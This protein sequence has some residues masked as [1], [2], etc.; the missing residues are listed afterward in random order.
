M[1][2]RNNIA[3]SETGFV[4]DP[5]TGDSFTLNETGKQILTMLSEGKTEVEIKKYFIEN[6]DVD[7]TTF[8]NNFSEFSMMLQS[9]NL[10]EE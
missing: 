8:E 7:T 3:V 2:V 1:K 6:F 9:L 10:I 5:N 4:F